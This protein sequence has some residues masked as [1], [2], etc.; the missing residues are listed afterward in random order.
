MFRRIVVWLALLVAIAPTSA[1]AAGDS[2]LPVGHFFTEANGGASPDYGFRISDEGGVGMWSEY[3]RLGGVAALGYPISRRFM[4][5][6]FISQ[7]T[8]K[9]IMQWRPDTSQVAFVNVFDLLHDMGMD[10]VLQSQYQIPPPIDSTVFDA[11]KTPDQVR[12]A[13]LD[14]LNADPAIATRYNGSPD[15]VTFNGLPTSTVTNT[16]PFMVLRAQRT[17]LQHWLI[18]NP[19]AGVSR[20]DVSMVNAGQIAKD[21]GVVPADAARPETIAGQVLAAPASAPPSPAPAAAPSPSSGGAVPAAT[22]T[23]AAPSAAPT[24]AGFMY[25]SKDVTA[26][27]MDCSPDPRGSA[28]PCIGEIGSLAVQFIRGRVM[29]ARGDHLQWVVVQATI[30]GQVYTM[31][32]NGDGTFYFQLAQGCPNNVITAQVMVLDNAGRQASDVKTITYSGNCYLSGEF[33]FDFV[34]NT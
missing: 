22:P 27:P 28:V 23:P 17:A 33:H 21:L 20:G 1:F 34:R 31:Q 11:G 26:P 18:D 6:G 19:A 16:G 3:Q 15:P 30:G 10:G 29:S 24:P 13:R 14:L 12:A 25:H 32:T 5:N 7:A 2:D 8:Q 9:V 4:L